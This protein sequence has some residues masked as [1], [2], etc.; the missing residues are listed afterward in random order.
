MSASMHEVIEALQWNIDRLSWVGHSERSKEEQD[1]VELA[2]ELVRTL[3]R[4]AAELR[5]A[6]STLYHAE[7]RLNEFL[8]TARS[9]DATHEMTPIG[10]ELYALSEARDHFNSVLLVG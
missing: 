7:L 4:Q 2:E 3:V 10:R 9:E 1:A 8:E 5:C 6:L